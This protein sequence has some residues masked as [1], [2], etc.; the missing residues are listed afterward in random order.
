MQKTDIVFDGMP[1]KY[2]V[3]NPGLRL[4]CAK[5]TTNAEIL[6]GVIH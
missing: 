5:A 1:K 2:R 6:I 4:E 3:A